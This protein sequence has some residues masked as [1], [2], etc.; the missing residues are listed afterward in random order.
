M[1][2]WDACRRSVGCLGGAF[3]YFETLGDGTTQHTP[4]MP[5]RAE[6]FTDYCASL[7]SHCLK[8]PDARLSTHLFGLDS[9]HPDI[10]RFLASIQSKDKRQWFT[11]DGCKVS[12][13]TSHQYD[14]RW[15]PVPADAIKPRRAP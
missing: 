1:T 8:N 14:K 2:F 11:L 3:G 15:H 7:V 12:T 4:L 5:A 9:A 13:S 10:I 6:H